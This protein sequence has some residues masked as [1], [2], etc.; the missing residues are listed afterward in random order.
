[1]VD[2]ATAPPAGMLWMPVPITGISNAVFP[3]PAPRALLGGIQPKRT[4]NRCTRAEARRAALGRRQLY[5]TISCTGE[6]WRT[7]S[8]GR[9]GPFAPHAIF[10]RCRH[11]RHPLLGR[12][13]G[14]QEFNKRPKHI[15]AGEGYR[16]GRID[17]VRRESVRDSNRGTTLVSESFAPAD[18]WQHREQSEKARLEADTQPRR[19][20]ALH[21][22]DWQPSI[23]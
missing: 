14:P 23:Q 3:P 13:S 18:C 6:D 7:A 15:G 10:A 21:P 19:P 9:A 12:A 11:R 2:E 1:M 5:R 17:D 16:A 8:P 4:A 22:A 20:P